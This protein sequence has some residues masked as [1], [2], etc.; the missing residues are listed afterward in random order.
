MDS[1]S[2]PH[3]AATLPRETLK[4]HELPPIVACCEQHG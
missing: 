3:A 4:N 1:E 2:K